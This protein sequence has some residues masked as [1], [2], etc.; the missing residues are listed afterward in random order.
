M[1][2]G[3]PHTAYDFMLGI[4]GIMKLDAY[5]F[6][7]LDSKCRFNSSKA[8]RLT[9]LK[10]KSY[11]IMT[12][13]VSVELLRRVIYNVGPVVIGLS[14]N[15]DSFFSYSSGIYSD[16]QCNNREIDHVVVV[17]GYGT[18]ETHGDYWIA[19]NS[20]GKLLKDY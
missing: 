16:E 1:K 13:P 19:K 7:G 5:P 4:K 8:F 6:E 17:V 2:G 11:Q 3:Y 10:L 14:G 15:L 18:D 9:D 20:W 12:P